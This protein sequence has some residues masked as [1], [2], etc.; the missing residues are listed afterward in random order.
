MKVNRTSLLYNSHDPTREYKA[1]SQT[2]TCTPTT[3]TPTEQ[4]RLH[5]D[6]YTP[7]SSCTLGA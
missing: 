5:V 4:L 6:G 2:W 1:A 7:N 3:N